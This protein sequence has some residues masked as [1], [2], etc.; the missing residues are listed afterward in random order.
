MILKDKD[1][2]VTVVITS[3]KR[4]DLLKITTD[5]FNT[6]N[7][8]TVK[9]IIIIDDSGDP[10]LHKQLIKD[11]PDYTLILNETNIG[12]VESIDKA[13]SQVT[14][15]YVFHTED[16]FEYIK[17]GFIEKS[18]KIM[19]SNSWIMQVWLSNRHGEPLENEI[20]TIDDV[21]YKMV[22]T[23][24]MCGVWHGFTFI[25]GLRSMQGYEMTKPW[26]QWS[27]STDGL[28]LR[29]C[30]I[31]WAYYKLGYRAACLLDI[32]YCEHTGNYRTTW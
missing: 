19:D 14:T 29:E 2:N 11:Y 27:P 18:M 6:M 10:E 24:G 5:S 23:G 28:S 3:Y 26:T 17:P 12:L 21:Q 8:Y 1:S 9:E 25:A 22:S 20:T 31:G 32:P 13:Y 4:L 15:P 16:D 30:K 7:T